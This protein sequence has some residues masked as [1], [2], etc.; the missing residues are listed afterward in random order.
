MLGTGG[1]S[2]L[3]QFFEAGGVELPNLPNK[4]SCERCGKSSSE[5]LKKCSKCRSVYYCSALCQTPHWK[6]HKLNCKSVEDVKKEFLK[7]FKAEIEESFTINAEDVEKFQAAIDMIFPVVSYERSRARHLLHILCNPFF[8]TQLSSAKD[9]QELFSLKGFTEKLM[10]QVLDVLGCIQ[11]INTK[12]TEALEVK[13]R[14]ILKLVD[15]RDQQCRLLRNALLRSSFGSSTVLKLEENAHWER[16]TIYYHL[17][18]NL[19]VCR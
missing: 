16:Y 2:S 13:Q 18:N 3:A 12:R 17:D 7:E 8:L 5:S 6:I 11:S 1:K 9:L 10:R 19:N 14:Q 15:F 4:E